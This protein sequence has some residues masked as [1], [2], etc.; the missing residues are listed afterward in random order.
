MSKR[1]EVYQ[2]RKTIMEWGYVIQLPTPFFAGPSSA[3]L[4]RPSKSIG[5]IDLAMSV[6][7]HLAFALV[8]EVVRCHPGYG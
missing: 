3:V 8:S 4:R 2:I 7:L 5:H 6:K 1:Q